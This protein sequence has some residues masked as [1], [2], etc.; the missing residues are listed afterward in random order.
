MKHVFKKTLGTSAAAIT[1]A[2]LMSTTA[3]AEAGTVQMINWLGGTEAELF[4]ALIADFEAKNEGIKIEQLAITGSGDQRGGI[5]ASLMGGET[6]DLIINTWPSFR[7]ELAANGMLR[8]LSGQYDSMGWNNQISASWKAT[9]ETGG[10]PYGLPF[11]YGFRSGLWYMPESLAA[12]GL[13]AV[14]QTWEEFLASFSALEAAGYPQPLALPAKV[15]AHAEP[16]E[17]ILLRVG[18]AA[19]VA[20]LAQ[21]EISWTDETVAKALGLY[22][23]MLRAGCCGTAETSLATEWNDAIDA[24]MV[25]KQ[26]AYVQMGMWTNSIAQGYDLAPVEDFNVAAF[27]ALGMGHDN[28]A[29]V[30]AKEI[31]A[32]SLGD[33]PDGADAFLNYMISADATAII[34]KAGFTSPSST[35]D[36]SLYSPILEKAASFVAGADVHFVLGDM[37]PGSLADEYRV[38]LQSFIMNPTD[39]NIAPTLEAIEAAAGTAY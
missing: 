23:E 18:G 14:P 3:L 17:T 28:E 29:I 30:D 25:N 16:F 24:V 20:K 7:D 13:N 12:A 34:A 11:V 19:T 21:H 37:L 36:T 31:L 6:P 2:T 15:W 9:S 4:N 27:P 26:S 1:L 10:V 8:D 38:S 39:E 35:T 33:N 32:T 5:R 22:G